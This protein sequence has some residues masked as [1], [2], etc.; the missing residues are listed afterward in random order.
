MWFVGKTLGNT[1]KSSHWTCK[2]QNTCGYTTKSLLCLLVYRNIVYST[3]IFLFSLGWQTNLCTY[4]FSIR[5]L[6]LTA[7]RASCWGV[8]EGCF[9]TRIS[10]KPG[11]GTKLVHL[12]FIFSFSPP[13]LQPV[14]WTFV[15]RALPGLL[16]VPVSSRPA[17]GRHF[18]R[19]EAEGRGWGNRPEPA[20][21]GCGQRGH[22]ALLTAHT[23]G[24][25]LWFRL[26]I[27]C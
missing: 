7:Q 23:G 2:S 9:L 22:P 3:C 16:I 11:I 19:C 6:E 13:L 14:R 5:R 26:K 18:V 27:P 10:V 25:Y 20:G 12:F 21:T 1:R 17:A 15:H 8:Q 24:R 4:V